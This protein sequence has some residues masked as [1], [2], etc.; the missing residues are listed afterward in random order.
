M[1]W[2][3]GDQPGPSSRAPLGQIDVVQQDAQEQG[4]HQDRH[5]RMDE[6]LRGGA[7][8]AFGARRAGE[9]P[10][11]TDQRDRRAEEHAFDQPHEQVEGPHELLRVEVVM[12]RVDPQDHH[13]VERAAGHA[14]EVGHDGQ[15]GDEHQAAQE[16]RH[17]EEVDRV[18]AQCFQGVDLLGDAHGAQFGRHGAAHP[19]GQHRGGQHRPQLA[20]QR[21]VDHGTEPRFQPQHAELGITLHGQ[22]HADESAGQRHDRQAQHA[23][24]VE[25]GYQRAAAR[26]PGHEPA[27]RAQ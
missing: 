25:A 16:P 1:R 23:D 13:A 17:D 8:H 4:E 21:H 26:P 14:H 5:E 6:G 2:G 9:S 27:E 3:A 15:R 18:G 10:V 7:P 22:H 19:A 24:L 12:V 20:H 11:A